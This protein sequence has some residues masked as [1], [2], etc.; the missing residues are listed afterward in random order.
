MSSYLGSVGWYRKDLRLPPGARDRSWVI[1]FEQVNYSATVWLNGVQVGSH[2]GAHEP[3]ELRLPKS[4]LKA[5]ASNSLVLRIDSR[6]TIN[7]L[8]PARNNEFGDP[9]GGWW[10]YAGILREVYLRAV[11]QI[12]ITSVNVR[13]D[14]PCPSCAAVVNW[15][16]KLSNLGAETQSVTVAG[17]FGSERLTSARPL[18]DPAPRRR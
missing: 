18:C 8:P 16:V 9:Q 2:S 3:F 1:R 11:D 4:L 15:Q 13:P 10:N 6:R 14:L 17:R 7:D 5:D 12:D